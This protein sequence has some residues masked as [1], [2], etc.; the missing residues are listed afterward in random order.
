MTGWVKCT[1]KKVE[2]VLFTLFTDVLCA[3]LCIQQLSYS[4]KSVSPGCVHEGT[5][6]IPIMSV[7]NLR[8]REVTCPRSK[9]YIFAKNGQLGVPTWS[10][11]RVHWGCDDR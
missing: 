3:G 9:K 11:L 5:G 1:S 2:T 6:V 4:I 10:E 7:I 8:L